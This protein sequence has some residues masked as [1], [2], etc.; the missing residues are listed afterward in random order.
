MKIKI[1]LFSRKVMREY[2][3][4]VAILS[5]LSSF[6]F[7][8]VSIPSPRK[9]TYILLAAALL[10]VIYLAIWLKA[11]LKT[12]AK[13]DIES[14]TLIV[15]TGDIFQQEGLKAIAFNEYFDTQVDDAIIAK[16]TL[17]GMYL[18]RFG[19]KEISALDAAVESDT[20]LQ[21][22]KVAVDNHRKAGKKTRHKLGSVFV[23]GEYLLVAFSHF[24]NNNRANLTLKEYI[25]CM[26]NF[27]DEVD[28]VYAGRSVSIPL[29]GSGITR[30]KDA[31]VH[32][33]ELLNILIWTFMVSRVK[34]K[35]PAKATIIIHG[36]MVDKINFYELGD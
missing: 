2:A 36:S 5:A 24:D 35:Y 23:H 4:T 14:S 32:E 15:R 11:N 31:S 26:L 20:R 1:P 9:P 12:S 18:S 7:I 28:Q 30:L 3:A 21:E 16:A 29:M 19:K 6:F 22:R 27:W 17:N 13:L 25:S 8:S 10:V 34:F 33:Q